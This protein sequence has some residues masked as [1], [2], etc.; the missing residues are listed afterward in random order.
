MAERNE[1][2]EA[3][4]GALDRALAREGPAVPY[5]AVD[6]RVVARTPKGH[7]K[8]YEDTRTGEPMSRYKRDKAIGTT[9]IAKESRAAALRKLGRELQS[10]KKRVVYRRFVG[11]IEDYPMGGNRQHRSRP[12]REM[13]PEQTALDPPALAGEEAAPLAEALLAGN[14]QRIAD[15]V[16]EGLFRVWWDT[17]AKGIQIS[18]VD[19]F[20]L[21]FEEV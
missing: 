10:G 9:R 13:N 17:E 8:T 12:G 20:E 16:R 6:F 19:E 15:A 18:Q 1:W 3:V 5:T 21:G 7:A 2:S 14:E 11:T 4:T